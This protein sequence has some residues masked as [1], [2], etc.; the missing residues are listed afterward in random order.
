MVKYGGGRGSRS[1][2]AGQ[3]GPGTTAD[4]QDH[5]EVEEVYGLGF[6]A[7]W[8]FQSQLNP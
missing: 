5:P 6:L 3:G 4:L 1:R 2:W 7:E 8:I